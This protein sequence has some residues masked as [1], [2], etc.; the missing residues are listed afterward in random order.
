MLRSQILLNLLCAQETDTTPFT[1]RNG[2]IL[3]S[4][5]LLYLL[6]EK[7]V[8]MTFEKERMARNLSCDFVISKVRSY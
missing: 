7:V 4:Q 6:Y 8:D 3:K 2:E 1:I 5:L